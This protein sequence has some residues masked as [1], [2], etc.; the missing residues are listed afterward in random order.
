[1]CAPTFLSEILVQAG[2]VLSP[3]DLIATVFPDDPALLYE[4][5]LRCESNELGGSSDRMMT[6]ALAILECAPPPMEEAQLL[7][8]ARIQVRLK[9]VP[10]AKN[11]YEQLLSANPNQLTWRL[12]FSDFLMQAGLIRE[13]RKEILTLL[14][15]RPNDQRAKSL[16][17]T[18]IRELAEKDGPRINNK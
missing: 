4:A 3:R 1:M 5:A 12:E 2:N 17:D 9:Q 11:S 7:L 14:S 6:K 10:A 13:A 8:Q 16:Y 15:F 18:V